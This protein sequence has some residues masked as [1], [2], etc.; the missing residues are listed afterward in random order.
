MRQSPDLLRKNVPVCLH[1]PTQNLIETTE[2]TQ[3]NRKRASRLT[4]RPLICLKI[5]LANAYW[6]GSKCAFLF[7]A[8]AAKIHCHCEDQREGGEASDDP[9]QDGGQADSSLSNW[10]CGDRSF[11]NYWGI[12]QG[13]RCAALVGQSVDA[14]GNPA[15]WEQFGNGQVSSLIDGQPCLRAIRAKCDATRGGMDFV[16]PY[17]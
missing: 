2:R 16:V 1:M 11:G 10:L 6:A 14:T 7:C 12:A 9:S 8:A 13:Q 15:N 3:A 17:R 4:E 5:Y